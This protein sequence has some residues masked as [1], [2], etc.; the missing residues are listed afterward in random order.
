MDE[1]FRVPVNRNDQQ[2]LATA[3][4]FLN[5]ILP[6]KEKFIEYGLPADF[7]E[8]LQSDVEKF[9]QTLA[10]TGEA[11]G[12]QVSSTAEIGTIIRRGMVAISTT[13]ADCQRKV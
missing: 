5:D 1:N 2:L 3:R 7:L 11:R 12:M 13:Q 9:E 4:A 8:N 6:Y 10:T